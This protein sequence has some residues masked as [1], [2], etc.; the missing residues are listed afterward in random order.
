M[1]NLLITESEKNNIL[2]M[3][4][5]NEQGVLDINDPEINDIIKNGIV[6]DVAPNGYILVRDMIMALIDENLKDMYDEEQRKS[7]KEKVKTFT[8]T[9]DILNYYEE[10]NK[11]P[12]I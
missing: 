9:K 3:Y 2:N 12:L 8:N 7:F 10:I 11:G 1:K 6:K 5:L 4:N